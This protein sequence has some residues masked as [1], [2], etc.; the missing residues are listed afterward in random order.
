MANDNHTGNQ[1]LA[2]IIRSAR[3]DRSLRAYADA[4]DVSYMTIFKA[5]RGDYIPSSKT[6]KKLTTGSANPQNGVT[7]EDMMVAA[8]YQDKETVSE[9]ASVLAQQ[10]VEEIFANDTNRYTNNT[11]SL[12]TKR[13]QMYSIYSRK[14]TGAIFNAMLQH[15]I[16]FTSKNSY[17]G[18]VRG[19]GPDIYLEV[20]KGRITE[21]WFDYRF[22][23]KERL[24]A[25]KIRTIL[26]S[27][28][29]YRPEKN[30]KL[31]IVINSETAYSYFLKQATNI[32]YRGELSVIL[33]DIENQKVVSEHYLS[34]YLEDDHSEEFFLV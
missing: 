25:M 5:E 31:S 17:A 10:M 28:L 7:Y 1:K 12:L 26:G 9:A 8:G 2:E 24:F 4:S 6:I 3:G 23:D 16:S 22:I 19:V 14:V 15:N 29:F 21:W 34:N 33:V 13:M 30:T 20:N 32:P 27:M 11:S 18:E